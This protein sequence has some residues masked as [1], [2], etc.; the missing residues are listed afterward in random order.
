MTARRLVLLGAV[1]AAA[2]CVERMTAPGQCPD[3]CPRGQIDSLIHVVLLDTNVRRDSAFRGYI[4]AH[5]S[6]VM[7]AAD[8]ADSSVVDSRAIFR[9]SSYGPRLV[10]KDTTTGAIQSADSGRLQF[11]IT[12]RDTAARNLTV[13]LYQLPITIDTLTTFADLA[14][15]F[16]GV[17]L[18][19][20]NVDSLIADSTHKDTV[21]GD[22]LVVDTL[23]HRVIVTVKLEG[24]QLPYVVA[25]TGKVAYGI[26]VSAD[27]FASIALGKGDLGP[28]L[29]PYVTVDSVGTP[30][31][32]KAPLRGTTLATFV[33]DPPPPAI[34][35]T[36][37][38]GGVPSA[39]SILRVAFPRSI[40]DSGQVIRGTL[41]LVPAVPARGA[42]ADSF[43]VEAHTVF[44]DFGAKSPIALDAT[45]TDTTVVHVG[46]RD[47]VRIEITNLLQFWQTDT[48]LAT[49]IVLKAKYEGQSFSEIRFYP[50]SV[51]ASRPT[52]RLTYVSRFPFGKP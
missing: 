9:F 10:V 40:R 11:Y 18:R 8:S 20:V 32:K 48:T 31:E 49:T 33:F 6:S 35:A 25:D 5:Q 47:T 27:S 46:S 24:S 1:L 37:A 52:I 17:P 41:I 39:R 36:L 22:S 12:R 13:R 38:V 23:N 15:D 29:Q 42:P 51:L 3:Y 4:L 16:V 45:R 26:R 30:V 14:T 7:L 50:S 43:V 21:T 19:T 28:L 44:A 2:A 34:G